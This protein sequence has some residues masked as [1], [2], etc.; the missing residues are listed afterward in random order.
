MLTHEQLLALKDEED[1][2]FIAARPKTMALWERAQ[3]SMPNG[4]PMSWHFGSYH[5]LMWASKGHGSRFQDADGHEYVDFNIADMSMFT[6]YGPEPVVRAV[7]EQVAQGSQ[8][9]LPTEDSVVVAEE[10]K[11][12]WDMPKWQF[13]LSATQANTEAIR[14]SRV[15]TGRD[16]VLMFEGKYH[17]HFDEALVERDADGELVREEEGLASDATRNTVL[18][19]WNDTDALAR[20]LERKDIALV[21]TEPALT[22]NV[23]LLLPEEGFH[24]TLRRLSRDNGTL[25]AIDETHTLVSG[26]GGL[27]KR[28][29]LEPDFVI[30]GKSIAAGIPMGTY[31]MTEEVA[32]FLQQ[33]K[34]SEG[35]RHGMIAT[36]GTLFGN[37]LQ[38]AAARASLTEVLTDA[39]YE[40][41]A[42]LGAKLADGLRTLVADGALPWYV[43]HLYP[44]SGYTFAPEPARNAVEAYAIDDHLLRRVI[45]I[46]MANRGVWEAIVGAGPVV[47]VPGTSADVDVYLEAFAGLVERLS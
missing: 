31:G 4:V 36:G 46:W 27:V 16:K 24:E 34:D 47:P 23:V 20:A 18:V 37:A 9:L 35:E 3:G 26:P 33:E 6:G 44:R 22:N 38:M 17:G 39:A 25:L 12:R 45:R 40:S 28:W 14:I 43:H 30:A 11:R 42:A 10:L 21:L 29:G 32:S 7:S 8:F 13:T 19:P 41:T 1:A 15:V 5:H 2:R